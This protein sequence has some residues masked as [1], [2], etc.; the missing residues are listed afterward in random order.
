[1]KNLLQP[2]N[3]AEA[4]ALKELLDRYGIE[5]QIRSFYDTAYDGI[6]QNQYGWGVIRVPEGD[7]ARAQKIIDEWRG[8]A[9]EDLPW[10]EGQ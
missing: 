7:L 8:A 9:P 2:E 6:F 5:A 3:E 4:L 1:M 10:R